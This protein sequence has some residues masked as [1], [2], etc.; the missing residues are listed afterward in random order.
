M[1]ST[2]LEWPQDQNFDLSYSF[3]K[4]DEKAKRYNEKVNSDDYTLFISQ[5]IHRKIQKIQKIQKINLK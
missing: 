5:D 1:K 3:V 2:D 4:L